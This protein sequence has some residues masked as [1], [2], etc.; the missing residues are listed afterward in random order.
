VLLR[1]IADRQMGS[2]FL[3]FR[4]ANEP[5]LRGRWPRVLDPV[6]RA[7]DLT[8]EISLDARHL[9][10]AA[11]DRSRRETLS[12]SPTLAGW[13]AAL[14][15]RLERAFGL[16][17]SPSPPSPGAPAAFE[18]PIPSSLRVLVVDDNPSYLREACELL[19]WWGI[20]PSIAEDGTEAV[21]LACRSYFDLI[22]MDLQMPLLDGLAATKQIRVFEH[23]QSFA[24][25]PVL[26]YTS[27][28]IEE[29]VL[30]DCGLDGVLEKPCNAKSLEEC[31]LRW[32]VAKT[33]LD[34]QLDQ[35]AAV[36]SQR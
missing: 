5:C 36:R 12:E 35:P 9:L 31:L 3:L 19:C 14:A 27:C 8:G 29:D 28:T 1:P 11:M 30:R 26:A 4:W 7:R 33:D 2:D 16:A 15:S 10:I 13:M 25:A 17:A 21:A 23:Q 6:G 34:A 24:R 20:Q 32:C 18:C 22:L